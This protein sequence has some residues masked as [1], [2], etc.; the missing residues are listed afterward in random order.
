MEV[1][2]E[3]WILHSLRSFKMTT[4][5]LNQIE[6]IEKGAWGSPSYIVDGELFW[7]Q[8]RL[9]FVE[10]KFNEQNTQTKTGIAMIPVFWNT[11]NDNPPILQ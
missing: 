7:G 5:L 6:V 3:L 1:G 2:N 9:P 11:F 10:R 8:D 4:V